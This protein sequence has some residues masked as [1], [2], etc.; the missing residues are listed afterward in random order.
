MIDEV[1]FRAESK[2]QLIGLDD[3]LASIDLERKQ[4]AGP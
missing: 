1:G 3:R 4:Q 2:T